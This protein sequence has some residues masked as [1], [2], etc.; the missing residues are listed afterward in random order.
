MN[1]VLVLRD[2]TGKV[3]KQYQDITIKQVPIWAVEPSNLL[4][5]NL[6]GMDSLISESI[7]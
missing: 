4:T 3:V 5:A 6:D 1:N 7:S 2:I